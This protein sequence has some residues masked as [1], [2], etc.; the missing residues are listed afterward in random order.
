VK[1]RVAYAGSDVGVNVEVV[2]Q[3]ERGDVSARPKAQ[4]SSVMAAVLAKHPE[5]RLIRMVVGEY[6][7]SVPFCLFC[8]QGRWFD[9]TGEEVSFL[10]LGE[11]SAPNASGR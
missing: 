2:A 5:I 1:V 11:T 3:W 6:R 8:A 10:L 7:Q 4:L 9:C